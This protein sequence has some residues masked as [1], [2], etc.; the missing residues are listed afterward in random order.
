MDKHYSDF[1]KNQRKESCHILVILKKK[2]AVA[3]DDVPCYD[4]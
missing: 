1:L 3:T 4:N 2:T